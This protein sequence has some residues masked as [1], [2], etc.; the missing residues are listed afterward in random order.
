MSQSYPT[1]TLL[2]PASPAPA[3]TAG[4]LITGDL[5]SYAR[6]TP[7]TIFRNAGFSSLVHHFH[8]CTDAGCPQTTYRYKG[9]NGTLDYALASDSLMPLVL[10]AWSWAINAEEPPALG[11]RQ[12][13]SPASPW[14]SSDHN[15]VIV[16]L[17]L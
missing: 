14:R 8:P 3:S 5:N 10:G 11:Y 15:P 6:E 13:A 4:T 17:A 16:D 12:N 1:T 2:A 7:L 9:R